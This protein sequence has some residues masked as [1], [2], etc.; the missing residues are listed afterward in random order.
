[1][2]IELKLTVNNPAVEEI[3]AY[4][5]SRFSDEWVE[6]RASLLE[7]AAKILRLGAEYREANENPLQLTGLAFV[8]DSPSLFRDSPTGKH[9]SHSSHSESDQVAC[10]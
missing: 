8:A 9:P 1:M 4:V 2:A 6:D 7:R 5:E 3:L 10:K